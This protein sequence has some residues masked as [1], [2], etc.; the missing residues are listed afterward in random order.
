MHMR[1]AQQDWVNESGGKY[2]IVARLGEKNQVGSDSDEV[3]CYLYGAA[4]D[5]TAVR[6]QYC[7][8]Y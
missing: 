7:V 3:V 5:G 6:S 8:V 4:C 1:P 2:V